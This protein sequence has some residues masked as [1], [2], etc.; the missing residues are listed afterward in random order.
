LGVAEHTKTSIL[1]IE[2]DTELAE[3][4]G[5]ELARRGYEVSYASDAQGCSTLCA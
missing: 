2:D 4:I 1:V 5:Q 3:A